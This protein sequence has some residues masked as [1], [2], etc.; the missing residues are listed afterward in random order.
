MLVV[1]V[2]FAFTLL[3]SEPGRVSE[4]G[5]GYVKQLS[6]D[7]KELIGQGLLYGGG[8]EFCMSWERFT[9]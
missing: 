4:L 9:A 6:E 3:L 2:R 8:A 1:K 7:L 5:R